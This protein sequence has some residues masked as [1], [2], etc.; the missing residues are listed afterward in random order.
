ME[1][2]DLKELF[3]MF[4]NKKT[5]I[6]L[7]VLM[8]LIV[9]VVYSFALLEPEYSSSTTLVLAMTQNDSTD[10]SITQTDVTLNSKLIS[11]YSELIKSKSV[12]REVIDNLHIEGITEGNVR[13]NISVKAVTDTELIKI[14]VTNEDPNVAAEIANEIAKVFSNKIVDIYNISNVYIVDRAEADTNPSNINHTKDLIIFA[15]IGIVIAVIYVLIV[16]MLDNTIKNEEDVEKSV[17]LLV[18]GS[19]PDYEVKN[20]RG[21]KR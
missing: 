9:G 15:F 17:G 19:I 8:L 14:T 11:T 2:L 4:W 20:K 6:I 21:G 16:N 7:I 12:L 18:L 5:E 13:G 1:E 3:I 10:T